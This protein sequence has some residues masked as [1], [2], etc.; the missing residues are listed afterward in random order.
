M[1]ERLRDN[2]L[3]AKLSKCEFYKEGVD[4]LGFVISKDGV[5][6]EKSRAEAIEEWPKPRLI[7]D[8]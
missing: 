7:R 1:L 2:Y 8:I 3:Y 4:F 5:A 6:I